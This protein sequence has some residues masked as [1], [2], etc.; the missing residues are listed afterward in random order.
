MHVNEWMAEARA[1]KLI[2]SVTMSTPK[3]TQAPRTN[4]DDEPFS[5]RVVDVPSPPSPT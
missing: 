2:H 5:P 4:D 1:A 3:N